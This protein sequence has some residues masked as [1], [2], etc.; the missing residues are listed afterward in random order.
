MSLVQ[1]PEV[2][3]KKL[4]ANRSNGHKSRGALTRAGKARAAASNLRHGFYSKEQGKTMLAQGEKPKDYARLLIS[5]ESNLA[6][7]LEGELVKHVARSLWRI[8]RAERMQ[9]GLAAQRLRN[10]LKMGQLTTGIKLARTSET[11]EVLVDLSKKLERPGYFPSRAEIEDF[12]NSFGDTPSADIQ[13]IF[14][15]LESLAKAAPR[16]PM[17]CIQGAARQVAASSVQRSAKNRQA[18]PPP[19]SPP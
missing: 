2:T 3:E 16:G 19:I 18:M 10:G 11:Y 6:D 13:Q 12:M 7:G 4:A 15:F 8:R 14:F 5:L 9:D 1:K 17:A